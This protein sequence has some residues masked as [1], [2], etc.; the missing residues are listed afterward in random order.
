[1]KKFFARNKE[2][3]NEYT[4]D[5]FEIMDLDEGYREAEESEY[6]EF[7]EAGDELEYYELEEE[8]DEEYLELEE[9]ED[10]EED[11]VHYEAEETEPEEE[12]FELEELE[13]T[14]DEE[15][16]YELEES[17]E[18]EAYYETEETEPEEEYFELEE[19]EDEKEYY[20]LEESEEDEAYYESEEAEPGEEYYE[21]D[22][23]EDESYYES[24]EYDD[25]M[26]YEE[27]WENLDDEVYYESVDEEENFYKNKVKTGRRR[28]KET[29]FS[30]MISFL[31]NMNTMDRLIAGTGV[32]VLVFA[33]VAGSMFASAQISA[34]QVEAFAE[35]GTDLDGVI[36]E[37][38]LVAV[39]DA[40]KAKQ[41]A[42]QIVEEPQT[43][44]SEDVAEEVEEGSIEVVMNLSSIQQ[45]LKIK[46]INKKTSKLIASVPFEI[47]VTDADKKTYT[48]KD[49]DMDG[50][51]YQSGL[52]A[53]KYSIS[54]IK[55]ADEE[56]KEYAVLT[57]AQQIT[58]KDKI[59]Y[60]KV[61]VVDEIKTEAEVNASVE[62]TKVQ[63]TVVE[64]ANK[65]TVAFVES[66]KTENGDGSYK[67]INKTTI[68]DPATVSG[69]FH[70]DTFMRLSS[71]A[72]PSETQPETQPTTPSE[73]QP[74]TQPTTPPETQPTTPPETQPTTPPETQPTTPPETQPTTPPET[75]PT[76]SPV[77]PQPVTL[78]KS[79]ITIEMG[80]TDTLTASCAVTWTSENPAVAA[81]DGNGTVTGAGAGTTRIIATSAEGMTA[82][83]SVTVT[84]VSTTISPAAVSI[85]AGES[86]TLSAAVVGT[87][88]TV[89]WASSDASVATVALN[90]TVTGIKAGTATITATANGVSAS[91]QVTVTAVNNAANDTAT[92][93]KD[94]Q[95]NQVYIKNE[96]GE[97]V[98]AVYADYYKYDKFYIKSATYKY[99]GWQTIDG[100]VYYYD[101]N[102]NVVTGT[103]VIQGAT[104]NFDASTG[105]LVTSSGVLGIDVSKWNGTIDW[106]A[107]K[108]AGVNYVIIRCG[109][110]GSSTGALIEDP[111]FRA[112]IKGATSSGLKV[113][114]YFFTQ[115]VNEVEAVEEASMVLSL[116]SG[117]NISYPVFLDVEP[118]GGRADSIS[119][120]TRT[121][122][123]NAFC[124][125]IANSGYATGIYANK[126]WLTSKINVGSLGSSY[127]IWLA[128][129]AAT[130]SY[131]GKYQMWQYSSKGSV[132]GIKGNVDM[133]LS[134]MGY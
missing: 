129:Y 36:G 68:T 85:K 106:N 6:G 84:A 71:T 53:G 95:G 116:I 112:N 65:D 69:L 56:Y 102:G 4:E 23:I 98:A 20:K 41:E 32:L 126:T 111:T 42:A 11:E 88:K 60:K 51:I 40:T 87:D 92:A 134:Y 59:E 3:W 15:E 55:L 57:D 120:D 122:V 81:V 70:M 50:I 21:L 110:R 108:N 91:C 117:Y 104:Y 119:A 39:A 86:T 83:C 76:T 73:T 26:Y 18:D 97:Y 63:E 121:A 67:E 38:A 12:Y 66:T 19:T 58:V 31:S 123:C 17:E 49:E 124:Q 90:G 77:T 125:T 45:D 103:Q 1:M 79:S 131:G 61:D 35:L 74:E 2:E 7:E 105:A 93:L 27:E 130:V 75:Q 25:D 113:G 37:S 80:K 64:S 46:F 54:M 30:R 109:Y 43:Q 133:N 99:T 78:N 5:D 10:E 28:K 52:A 127:K 8:A 16:Y 13:E 101:A 107:V 48:L 132:P 24:E 115:A 34:G 114:V 118:S 33:I 44:P 94:N 29:V 96:A 14:E 89:V 47:E 22:E 82:A 9:I 62:D 100:S 128:Q 72:I